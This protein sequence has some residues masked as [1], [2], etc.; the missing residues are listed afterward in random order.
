MPRK[1]PTT[2]HVVRVE[3]G[4]ETDVSYLRVTDLEEIEESTEVAV[5]E[6]REVGDVT[7]ERKYTG[8]QR[9]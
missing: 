9:G 3:K 5:Y 4:A 7:I 2:I 6:L 8:P 1:F